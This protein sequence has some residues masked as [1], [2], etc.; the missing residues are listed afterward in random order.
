ML[1]EWLTI[2]EPAALLRVS[3][4]RVRQLV[5]AG[6]LVP[7]GVHAAGR[8]RIPRP[9]LEAEIARREPAP[10][11]AEKQLEQPV[12]RRSQT[13]TGAHL[14][15]ECGPPRTKNPGPKLGRRVRA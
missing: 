6:R 7:D 13:A 2:D 11:A 12:G 1:L 8:T 3:R 15:D 14:H 9:S 5:Q 4:E 10:P